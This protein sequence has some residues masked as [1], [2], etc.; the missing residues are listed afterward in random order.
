LTG[1]RPFL[2]HLNSAPLAAPKRLRPGRHAPLAPARRNSA[3][4]VELVAPAGFEATA[5]IRT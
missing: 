5:T 1:E 4:T 2:R 3:S